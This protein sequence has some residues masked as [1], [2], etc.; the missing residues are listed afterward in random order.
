MV[1]YALINFCFVICFLFIFTCEALPHRGYSTPSSALHI[2]EFAVAICRENLPPE[3]TV[4]ICRQFFVFVSK[5]FFVYVNKSCLYESK[6]FSY[7]S[8]TF[9]FVR[10]SLLTVF[11]FV[12][13]VTVTLGAE[14]FTIFAIFAH[15]RESFC[16]RK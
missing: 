16:L 15:F 2:R 1:F 14:T 6:P 3:F 11:L 10:F 13:A 8:K 9:L 12:I 7:V 5:S 4:A